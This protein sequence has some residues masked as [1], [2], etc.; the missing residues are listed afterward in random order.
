MRRTV[1]DR[2]EASP[3]K[4]APSPELAAL[5]SAMAEK[6]WAPRKERK[7][8]AKGKRKAG[9]R[10]LPYN[11]HV[12]AAREHLLQRRLAEEGAALGP[13]R[14]RHDWHIVT[15]RHRQ[16]L[17]RGAAWVAEL[18]ARHAARPEAAYPAAL[19]DMKTQSRCAA[20][21]PHDNK[22]ISK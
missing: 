16:A 12:V 13:L 4:V 14:E 8:T 20:T 17:A 10:P 19:H 18:E 11:A 5:L 21:R 2:N 22:D 9:A 1:A 6:A 3:Y 7:G 15:F